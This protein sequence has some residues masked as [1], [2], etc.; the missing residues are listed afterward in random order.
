MMVTCASQKCK[1]LVCYHNLKFHI[2]LYMNC[3]VSTSYKDLEEFLHVCCTTTEEYGSGWGL[4]NQS[5]VFFEWT[6]QRAGYSPRDNFDR[7]EF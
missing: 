4:T 5:A 2:I 6:N 7:Y 1:V 3:F